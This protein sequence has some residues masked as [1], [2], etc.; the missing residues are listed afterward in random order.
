MIAEYLRQE[1]HTTQIAANGR[2]GWSQFCAGRFDLVITDR[3]MPEMNG[4]QL[5][6]AIKQ[7]APQVPI[8][9]LTG[10]GDLMTGMGA[11]PPCVDHVASKP[12]AATGLR[13]II[14]RLTQQG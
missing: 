10:F 11:A 2:E 9:L 3:A 5:A 13:A 1:G 12:I 14:D 7:V 8:L 4:D 6:A